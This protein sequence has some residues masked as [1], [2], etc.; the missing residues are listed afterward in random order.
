MPIPVI[1][2]GG[3]GFLG[4]LLIAE[5]LASQPD[6]AVTVIDLVASDQ[7]GVT[8]VISDLAN[9]GEALAPVLDKEP[10]RVFHLASV[11]SSAAEQDWN[12]AV[13]ANIAGFI[14]LLT[15]L[16]QSGHIHQLTFASSVAVFGGD[17]AS[18]E[19]GPSDDTKQ[20][21][22]STYGMTKSVG[23]LLLNDATRKGLIDGRV[24]RLP[25][26]I[27]R[28]GKPNAA[29]SSFCSGMFREPLA[30]IECAIPV[31]PDVS[32]VVIGA[33]T[34]AACLLAVSG[35]DTD[36]IGPSRAISLPG[37]AVTVS[38]MV[39]AL[40]DVGGAGAADL[41]SYRFDPAI[42]SIVA[43][44]PPA[45]DDTRGRELKLPADASLVSIISD[46]MASQGD[47]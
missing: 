7:R 18:D 15:A 20:T 26:V 39:T 41:L 25:T 46:Y 11:V 45:W 37:L 38:E 5:I 21:P 1:V 14:G 8:S 29:A 43:G 2:T 35:L 44:W 16:S 17:I 28:P 27:V 3:A 13:Q 10:C 34:A 23:E 6:T 12:A 22:T 24:A 40:K 32:I 9:A 33:S 19:A 4:R 47:S 36:E 31:R 42:E 30:G